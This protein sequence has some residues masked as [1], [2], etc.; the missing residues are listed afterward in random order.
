MM[1]ELTYR[2]TM[3]DLYLNIK[4][5]VDKMKLNI[6]DKKRYQSSG[7]NSI[8]ST[9]TTTGK[10]NSVAYQ[11]KETFTNIIKR[12]EVYLKLRG[13]EDEQ[14]NVYLLINAILK[15]IHDKLNHLYL[16][17]LLVRVTKN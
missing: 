15:L 7:K 3:Q 2:N 17:N 9:L 13:T 11:Q 4:T 8:I 5:V 16:M 6:L 14:T 12:F 10:V 1:K